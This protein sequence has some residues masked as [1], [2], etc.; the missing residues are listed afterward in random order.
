MRLLVSVRSADEVEA[1]LT[2]GADIIDAKEPAR[3]ALGAVS[4]TTL[5]EI[6]RRVPANRL[7]SVALGD[8]ATDSELAAAFAVTEILSRPAPTFLKLGFAGIQSR[9]V[10]FSLLST[11]VR[12]ASLRR[13]Q[14]QVI[15]VAYADTSQARSLGPHLISSAAHAAGAAGVLIDTYIKDG[16]NLFQWWSPEV[17]ATWILDARRVGLMTGVAGSLSAQDVGGLAPMLPDVLGFRGAAC[18]TGRSGR[19]SAR[20][21]AFLRSQVNLAVRGALAGSA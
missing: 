14:L 10:V 5:S 13:P 7:M 19:V 11:A 18:D 17:L 1:A 16:R 12:L 3:G 15:A 2:G 4:A 9:E 21:V 20:R 6:S 8:L